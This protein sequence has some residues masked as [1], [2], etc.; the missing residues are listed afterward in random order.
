M[1]VAAGW[2]RTWGY[3]NPAMQ[4]FSA[5]LPD[6]HV[7]GGTD[8][9]ANPQILYNL[10]T[11]RRRC[12]PRFKMEGTEYRLSIAAIQQIELPYNIMNAMV[13]DVFARTFN[14]YSALLH[15]PW[16]QLWP[17][18]WHRML[19]SGWCMLLSVCT[20]SSHDCMWLLKLVTTMSVLSSRWWW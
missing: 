15:L 7:R 17:C 16:N 1:K 10:M 20:L 9:M 11:S 6:G 14:I 5:L 3:I 4:K 2:S 12:I 8:S 13:H 19:V 18:V